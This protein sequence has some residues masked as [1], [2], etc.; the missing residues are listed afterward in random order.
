[1][2]LAMTGVSISSRLLFNGNTT[3]VL[4]AI[5]FVSTGLPSQLVLYIHYVSYEDGEFNAPKFAAILERVFLICGVLDF[6]AASAATAVVTAGD[7]ALLTPSTDSSADVAPGIN[8]GVPAAKLATS[9]PVTAADDTS[10]D[11]L[12]FLSCFCGV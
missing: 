12:T 11:S 3:G 6:V 9:V 5:H 4:L 2:V 1:M 10:V 7:T 8:S